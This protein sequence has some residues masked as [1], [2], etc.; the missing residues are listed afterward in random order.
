MERS[1]EQRLITTP[2]KACQFES[3]KCFIIIYG[4]RDTSTRTDT[5]THL[6]QLFRQKQFQEYRHIN[7]LDQS[8]FR[9]SGVPA[10]RA[11]IHTNTQTHVYQ[12]IGPKQFQ[13]IRIKHFQVTRC[14]IHRFV[15]VQIYENKSYTVCYKIGI[16]CH[17][18]YLYDT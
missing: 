10:T 1:C 17:V 12:S 14:T 4:Q 3:H 2:H 11:C 7:Q 15:L 9:K 6:Y 13:E 16:M 8:S 18:M 5:D